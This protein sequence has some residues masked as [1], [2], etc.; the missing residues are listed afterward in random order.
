[1]RARR[2]VHSGTDEEKLTFLRSFAETDYLIAQP[3]LVPEGFHVH[4][5]GGDKEQKMPIASY[6]AVRETVPFISLFED[7][8]Q[9]MEKQLPAQTKLKIG[10]DPVAC[11]TPLLGAGDGNMRPLTTNIER[12]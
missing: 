7:A 2:Y 12:F 4:P 9:A 11:V 3:F 1:M 10:N 5:V 6:S 8:I